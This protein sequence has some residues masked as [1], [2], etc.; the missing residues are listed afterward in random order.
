MTHFAAEEMGM[1]KELKEEEERLTMLFP[2][3]FSETLPA[4]GLHVHPERAVLFV[5]GDDKGGEDGDEDGGFDHAFDLAF[6]D[7][8]HVFV[9]LANVAARV[10]IFEEVLLFFGVVKVGEDGV[11]RDDGDQ[12]GKMMKWLVRVIVFSHPVISVVHVCDRGSRRGRVVFRKGLFLENPLD[13]LNLKAI[14]RPVCITIGIGD[15]VVGDG[16]RMD[17]WTRGRDDL[18][19]VRRICAAKIVP[20]V[21]K[22][23]G[24]GTTGRACRRL[25]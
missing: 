23:R 7:P 13:V 5:K 19:D 16:G 11:G 14:R 15:V 25:R 17:D 18:G 20:K 8:F 6:G 9:D 3:R 2:P 4:P 1:R 10:C 12:E 24:V 22:W 21:I